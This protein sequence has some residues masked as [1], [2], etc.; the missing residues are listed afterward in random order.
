MQIM[1]REILKKTDS[2]IKSIPKI[3]PLNKTYDHTELIF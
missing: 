1:Y 3:C 2:E